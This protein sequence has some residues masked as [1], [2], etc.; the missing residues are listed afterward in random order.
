MK[1]HSKEDFEQFSCYL[2]DFLCNLYNSCVRRGNGFT[3]ES[4]RVASFHTP[5]SVNEEFASIFVNHLELI[6]EL[7]E[8]QPEYT[9]SWDKYFEDGTIQ[10]DSEKYKTYDKQKVEY[11]AHLKNTNHYYQNVKLQP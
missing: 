8:N 9:I 10:S 4:V 6:K 1:T 2:K 5:S 3:V 7:A 11:Y